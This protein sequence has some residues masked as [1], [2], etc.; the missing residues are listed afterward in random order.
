MIVSACSK[1]TVSGEVESEDISPRIISKLHSF[2][3]RT[4]DTT[5]T[6]AFIEW[7]SAV[8]FY[9]DSTFYSIF[10]N[11]SQVATRNGR[12]R[13]YTFTNLVPEQFYTVKIKAVNNVGDSIFATTSFKTKDPYFKFLKKVHPEFIPED[14]DLVG[15]NGYIICGDTT[16]NNYLT[17]IRVDSAGNRLWSKIYKKYTTDDLRIKTTTEGYLVVGFNFVI[18]LDF[19]G[20]LIWERVMPAD[21]QYFFYSFVET[22]NREIYVAGTVRNSN[23]VAN[24]AAIFKLSANGDIIWTKNYPFSNYGYDA[25]IDIIPTLNGSGFYVLGEK[26]VAAPVSY[27]SMIDLWLFKIDGNGDMLWEKTYGDS[28]ADKAKQIKLVNNQ[29]IMGYQSSFFNQAREMQV[30]KTDMNGNLLKTIA[31]KSPAYSDLL[32]SIE[33]TSDNGF[34][35]VADYDILGTTHAGVFKFDAAGNKQWEK[36]Y[37][38]N[39]NDWHTARTIKQTQDGGFVIPLARIDHINSGMPKKDFWMVKTNPTGSYQ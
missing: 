2:E 23:P 26:A 10:L 20:N 28:R 3:I 24:R 35:A 9:Y 6:T 17:L 16:F 18:K 5:A 29:L 1:K 4:P 34:I 7:S 8:D 15:N 31:L 11:G 25:A 21:G 33:P 37:F 19:S 14:M 39:Q 22:P 32:F 27:N 12:Q 30:L 13:N 36:R 38:I